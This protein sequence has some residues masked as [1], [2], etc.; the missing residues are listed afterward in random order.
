MSGVVIR[1]DSRAPIDG[2]TV[3]G[4]G[5]T[6][7]TNKDG[8]F[9]LRLPAGRISVTVSATTF[10]QLKTTVD[11]AE[12]DIVDAEFALA[13]QAGVRID[14]RGDCDGTRA[15][16]LAVGHACARRALC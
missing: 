9:D 6:T 15:F 16:D 8:R 7:T 14:R 2:A 13:P 3:A 4:G 10:Y 11:L 5:K 1:S 12:R